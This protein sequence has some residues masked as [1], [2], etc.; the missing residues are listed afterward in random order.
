MPQ[1]PRLISKE[2]SRL[3]RLGRKRDVAERLGLSLLELKALTTDT[4]FREWKSKK[5]RLIE[6]PLPALAST[7]SRLH[8]LLNKIDMPAYLLSGKK[9]IKPRDNADM[10]RLNNYMIT[11]D[12]EGFYRST[13]REFVYLAFRDIFKQTTDV[14]SLLADLVT[15][16]GHIPTG[17]ATS[18]LIAFLA[19]KKTF[20]RINKLCEAQGVL[21]SVW[22]DDITFSSQKPFPRGWVSDIQK[23]MSKVD[24]SLKITKTKKYSSSEY[25]I[26]TGSAISPD[27]TLCVKNE[28]RKEIFDLLKGRQIEQL[29][30]K[31]TR[32]VLGKLVA[33]RQNEEDFF[34]GAY[35]RCRKRL[36][37]LECRNKRKPA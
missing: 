9:G 36:I 1:P 28:K 7:L 23:I 25:K 15:Y 8:L 5:G 17:T 6:E 31:E 30:I 34:E 29:P 26:A 16:Q 27:G 13:K 24:L 4:N 10:H 11:V 37:K 22:V 35:I 12:I 18:Q 33:Q 3:Y 2:E 21:M 32:Q 20:D 19:Y 14:A